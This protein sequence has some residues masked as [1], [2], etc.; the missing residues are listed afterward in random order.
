[1]SALLSIDAHALNDAAF[2]VS[3]S[4]HT[5]SSLALVGNW[6]PLFD[7]LCGRSRAPNG[8]IQVLGHDARSSV[9]D[10][11]LGVLPEFVQWPAGQRVFELLELSAS[12]LGQSASEAAGQ[13]Q[14]ALR[15]LEIE[16]QRKQMISRLLPLQLR[17]VGIAHA[18]L[19]VP[20]ALALQNPVVGLPTSDAHALMEALGR[21]AAEHAL[22]LSVPHADAGSPERALVDRCSEVIVL[23]QGA[24][25]LQGPPARLADSGGL[26][27][28]TVSGGGGAAL[29][30]ALLA[31]GVV[32]RS[33]ALLARHSTTVS[34]QLER[35]V[36]ELGRGQ[37]TLT[38]FR[39]AKSC[40]ATLLELRSLANV[41]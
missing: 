15:A 7:V 18:L 11:S 1:M 27:Q 16:A 8:A 23:G 21:L 33:S 39:A 6:Q 2:P 29:R 34:I 28:L 20:R 30:Q 3:I 31:E 38:L 9:L 41:E 5:G 32:V 14:R 22:I 17:R 26:L 10:A 24:I 40:G 19:G 12:L 35:L 4:S 37:S 36:V 25:T 13:A